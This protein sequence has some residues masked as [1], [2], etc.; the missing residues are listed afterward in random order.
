VPFNALGFATKMLGFGLL[1]SLSQAA[2][3][4]VTSLNTGTNLNGMESA[5]YNHYDPAS[6]PIQDTDYPVFTN[7]LLNY[8]H[9]QGVRHIR[10]VFAWEAMQSSL[11]G[12]IPNNS[13]SNYSAYWNNYINAVKR[14]LALGISVNCGMWQYSA[15]TGGTDIAYQGGTFQP[16]DFGNFW[17]PFA[18]AVNSAT[19][20]DQ[21]VSF[22]L[23]NEPHQGAIVAGDQI[24]TWTPYA[25]A[26]IT[27]IR[28]TGATN[29]IL[30]S[31]YNYADCASFTSDGSSNE[32]LSLTDPGNNLGVTAH[33]YDGQLSDNISDG[34]STDPNALNNACSALISWAQTHNVLVD[35]GEIAIDNG[36][37]NGSLSLAQT[38]WTNWQAFCVA[39]KANLISW[40]WWGCSESQAGYDWWSNE[41]STGRQ[42]WGL[43]Q[44]N[45]DDQ[46][47]STYLTLLTSGTGS[48]TLGSF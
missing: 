29:L 24:S 14:L 36:N 18:A 27:A 12:S 42:N 7:T 48:N 41:D 47:P 32:F 6:G 17:G 11:G 37:P 15:D 16:S 28:N 13:T 22:D 39:N 40:N 20:N 8:L 25:Q 38:Q 46:T 44:D 34:G 23:I 9:S 2:P 5:T 10:F 43:I 35:I 30:Y 3:P 4:V 31:G 1:Q 45:T 19:G 21:R 26:A 33:N